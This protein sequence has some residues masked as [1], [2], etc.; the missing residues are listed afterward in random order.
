LAELAREPGLHWC[1]P[2]GRGVWFVQLHSAELSA[3]AGESGRWCGATIRYE[4]DWAEGATRL[5]G[6]SATA[7]A[8]ADESGSPA[9]ERQFDYDGDGRQELFVR[10]SHWENGGGLEPE[11]YEVLRATENGVEPYPVGFRYT[12]SIDADEDGRPDLIDADYYG[13]E[14][15]CGLAGIWIQGPPLLVHSLPGGKFTMSDETS[16]RW[17]IG[18]CPRLPPAPW[19]EPQPAACARIWGKTVDQVASAELVT[20][21]CGVDEPGLAARFLEPEPPFAP[22]ATDT[23]TPLPSVRATPKR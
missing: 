5:R 21:S 4:I 20:R 13:V 11:R 9:I 14:L 19:I 16:R 6:P 12:G 3:P 23:P 1:K 15:P 22:L 17:A 10:T 18:E 2:A 7:T 8:H